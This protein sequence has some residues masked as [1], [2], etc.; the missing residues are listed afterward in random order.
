MGT[1]V[2]VRWI[3]KSKKANI[4]EIKAISSLVFG[5]TFFVKSSARPPKKTG[6]EERITKRYSFAK[7]LPER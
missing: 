2:R 5:P 7:S 4:P 3:P 6:K 1:S